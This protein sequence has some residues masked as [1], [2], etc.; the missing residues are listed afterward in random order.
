MYDGFLLCL[1]CC[2]RLLC[3]WLLQYLCL[4]LLTECLAYVVFLGCLCYLW[5]LTV[6]ALSECLCCLRMWWF[7]C[8]NDFCVLL[9][10]L[11]GFISCLLDMVYWLDCCDW[12]YL[13]VDFGLLCVVLNL[14][15][16][17]LLISICLVVCWDDI[18]WV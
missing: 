1:F 14:W 11:L 10:V 8:L 17:L 2:D 15:C 4:L 3:G 18:V 7:V 6:F 9:I 12:L 16:L 5:I 13:F